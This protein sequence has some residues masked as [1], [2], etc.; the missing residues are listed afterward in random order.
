M[1]TGTPRAVSRD[2][3]LTDTRSSKEPQG[4]CSVQA[5]EKLGSIHNIQVHSKGGREKER[6]IEFFLTAT[7]YNAGGLLIMGVLHDTDSRRHRESLLDRYQIIIFSLST[8]ENN[9]KESRIG[10]C[11]E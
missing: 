7:N 9:Y 4:S 6:V 10:Y 3:T 5:N 11:G 8:E 1:C 2:A